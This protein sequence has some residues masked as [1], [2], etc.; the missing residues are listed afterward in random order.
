MIATT[1]CRR[2]PVVNVY[3]LYGPRDLRIDREELL[4]GEIVAETVL[5]LVS[6]GTEIAAYNGVKPLRDVPQY[7][8]LMGYCNLARVS[9][10]YVLTHQSHRS[11]FACS[12]VD[13]LWRSSEYRPEMVSAYLYV[14]AARAL[15]RADGDVCIVGLGALGY[16]CADLARQLGLRVFVDTRQQSIPNWCHH[17]DQQ[18]FK[19]VVL[20]ASDWQSYRRAVELSERA[21]V[22]L[23]LPGRGQDTDFNP[24][25]LLYPRGLT[26]RQVGE[27]DFI[28]VKAYVAYIADVMPY[29]DP[30]PLLHRIPW[31]DLESAYTGPRRE[32]Q[33]SAVLEWQPQQ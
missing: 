13:V 6:P 9:D 26:I 4:S 18:T 10:G 19:H 30:E 11:A 2:G 28:N 24:L 8:R 29:L 27:T 14:L 21:V 16:A 22:L 1:C 23:G 5:S 3:R 15:E 17:V 31:T 32:G 12:E 7:P 20:T 25:S 33:Y